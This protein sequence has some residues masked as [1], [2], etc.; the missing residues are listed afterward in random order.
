[1]EL[2]KWD[3]VVLLECGLETWMD[4]RGW[5]KR[6]TNMPKG[7]KWGI[8]LVGRKNKKGRVMGK[9]DGIKWELVEKGGKVEVKM[10]EIIVGTVRADKEKWRIIGVYV[11]GDI[12]E[13]LQRVGEWM[14]EKEKV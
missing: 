5:K 13:K 14:E 11:N 1:M 9:I 12:K 7:F 3:V 10:E 8:Q 6:S 4:E 2:K